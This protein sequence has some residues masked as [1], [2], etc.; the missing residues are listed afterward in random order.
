M[1]RR[2]DRR[3]RSSASARGRRRRR[4]RLGGGS[5][6]R[7]RTTTD[8]DGDG[9]DDVA[10]DRHRRGRATRP[11]RARGARRHPRLRR[12]PATSPSAGRARS[13]ALPAEGTVVERGGTLGEVERRCRCRCSTATGPMWR[14]LGEGAD[15][16]RRP[17]R[18]ASSRRTSSPSGYGTAA[19]PRADEHSSQAT[20]AAVKAWQEA[21]GVEETGPR[22]PRRGRVRRRAAA[23]R[24]PPRRARVAGAGGAGPLG[25]PAPSGSSTVDLDGEPAGHRSTVGQA[26][27]VELPDGTVV[28]GTVLVGRH[29]RRRPAIRCRARATPIGVVVV[30]RRPAAGGGARRGARRGA[31]SSSVAGR[32]RARRPGRGAAGAGR[33][34]LRGRA[35]PTAS[36]VGGRGRCLRRRLRRG[37]C[38]AAT[39]AEGDDVVVPA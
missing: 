15:I 23:H 30:A 28:A 31:T 16:D 33:G 12:Q 10:D 29:R 22:R 27:E 14:S 2:E 1:R 6:R 21:L 13:P 7:R 32:G 19:R 20:T 17:R 9:S 4:G 26:V 39:L 36:L 34:R 35:S 11:R 37:R 5:A 38:P 18:R 25:R 8:G 24:R 3:R